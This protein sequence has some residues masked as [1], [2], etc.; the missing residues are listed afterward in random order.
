MGKSIGHRNSP[1]SPPGESA[2]ELWAPGM[3]WEGSPQIK[4]DRG[5]ECLVMS[6]DS[7]SRCLPE[8]PAE[9][10]RPAVEMGPHPRTLLVVWRGA[11][12]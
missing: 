1:S 5:M 11:A 8:N 4:W 12:L 9:R 2:G 7:Y 6:R 3:T 10:G